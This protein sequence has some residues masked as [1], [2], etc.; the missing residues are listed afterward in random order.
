MPGLIRNV[1]AYRLDDGT[2]IWGATAMIIS[3]LEAVLK[4]SGTFFL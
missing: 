2:I 3:E 1:K 4:E